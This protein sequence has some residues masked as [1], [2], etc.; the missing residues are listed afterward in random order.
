MHAVICKSSEQIC[1]LFNQADHSREPAQPFLDLLWLWFWFELTKTYQNCYY[2]VLHINNISYNNDVPTKGI[3]TAWVTLIN[4]LFVQLWNSFLKFAFTSLDLSE[5]NTVRSNTLRC[6]FV[7]NNWAKFDTKFFTY[8][9]NTVTFVLEY[10][11]WITLYNLQNTPREDNRL[12]KKNSPSAI[13]SI[14]IPHKQLHQLAVH[15]SAVWE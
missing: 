6:S 7:L 8:F 11:F 13:T 2:S 14:S 10:F 5:E 3:V 1:R 15:T 12:W 9:W 4:Q